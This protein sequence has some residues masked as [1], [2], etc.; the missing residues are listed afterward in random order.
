V[1]FPLLY[2]FLTV[3][4]TIDFNKRFFPKWNNDHCRELLQRFHLPLDEPVKTYP[5]A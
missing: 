2:D 3:K 4:D 5:G 1:I